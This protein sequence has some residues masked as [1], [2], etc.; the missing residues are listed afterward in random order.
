MTPPLATYRLQLTPAFGFAATRAVLDYL[1]ALGI[2]DLYLSPLARAR[3]GSDHGYDVVDPAVLNPELGSEEEFAALAAAVKRFGLGW[4][5]DIV[6]NHMAFHRDNALLTDILENGPSARHYRFFDIDWERAD[7]PLHG[8]LLAPFLGRFFG[9]TLE[10]GELRLG[11][12]QGG[13]SIGYFDQRFA[14]RIES[15]LPLLSGLVDPLRRSLGEEH[16]DYIQLLGVLYVLKTLWNG[17]A[18]PQRYEQVIFVKTTLAQLQRKDPRIAREL[19]AALV[20]INGRPGDPASFN[21]LEALLAEQHVRLAFWKVATEEINYRR[22]FS[23]NEL[24]SVRAEDPEVFAHTHALP[25]RLLAEGIA[26]GLRVD[27]IDGLYDPGGYLRRLR[28]E[29][30]GC[31]LVVEKILAADEELPPEWPVAGTTGYDFLNRINA[32]FVEERSAAAFSR[33]YRRFTGQETPFAELRYRTKRLIIDKHMLGD[34]DNLAREL[35]EIA[36]RSRHGADLTRPGLRQALI[37]V[38]ALLPVYRTYLDQ[39]GGRSGDAELVERTVAAAVAKAPDQ[40]GA[41]A[42]LK[43]TLLLRYED[44]LAEEERGLWLHFVRRF[45]QYTGALMAKGIEDTLLYTANRLLSLNEVGGDPERFG[46]PLQALHAFLAARQRRSPHALSA[47]STHDTKRGEDVRARLNVLAEIPQEWERQLRAWSR[48]NRRHL[49]RRGGR[50]IPD[51]NDE[52]FLYQTLLGA[53]PFARRED[54]AFGRRLRAYA[55]KAVREAKVHTAWL[56]PDSAYEEGYLAFIDAILRRRPQSPFLEEFLP[57][58]RRI[59]DFGILNSLAQ[60]LVKLTAP[61]VPDFYQGSELWELSL[62]DPDNRRPVDYAARRRALQ[63]IVGIADEELPQLLRTLWAFPAALLLRVEA[64]E[65][66]K[67]VG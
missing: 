50:R 38:M 61:G 55:V 43:K 28:E 8:R 23:I 13:F 11:Y 53:Y 25:L 10:K 62:V 15:Y 42:F 26:S 1:S 30:G 29:A 21:G 4:L 6:P 24:I 36:G 31:Y 34:L 59:A 3:P 67:E 64:S 54:A 57:F 44:T 63:G 40:T 66:T 41:L 56:K 35:K 46:A 51:K 39:Q 5:Q 48:L 16:P 27:H 20:R 37:E 47:T 65:T 45:Q 60:T 17:P 33:L 22:F 19:D 32:L 52:Y 9:E 2:S 18:D 58:W 7:P 12:D 49:T 14:L